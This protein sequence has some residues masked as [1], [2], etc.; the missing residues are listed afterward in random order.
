MRIP[1]KKLPN[2]IDLPLPEYASEQSAGL[3]LVAAISEPMQLNSGER[4]LI[5]CGVALALPEGYEAQIRPRSGLAYKHGLTILN[6]PGTIDSDYRGE[7]KVL[8]INHGQ[9]PY[10]IE[11][12]MRVAQMVIAPFSSVTWH[13]TK[14]LEE[15]SS[16]DRGGGFGSSGLFAKKS[17]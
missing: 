11:R 12:G 13:E 9:E 3:D 16:Q 1:I 7:I 17:A 5:P 15:F 8:L 14:N 2:G 6:A 4:E 10:V